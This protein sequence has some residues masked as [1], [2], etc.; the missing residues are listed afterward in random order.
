MEIHRPSSL[1]GIN[2]E[3]L[4]A[5]GKQLV[6][7]PVTLQRIHKFRLSTHSNPG[8]RFQLLTSAKGLIPRVYDCFLV[9]GP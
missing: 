8:Q 9:V 1:D 7:A 6:N 2:K 3:Q 4:N 5:F